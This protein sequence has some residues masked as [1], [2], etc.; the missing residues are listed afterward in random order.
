MAAILNATRACWSILTQGWEAQRLWQLDSLAP[1]SLMILLKG[2]L[3]Q[4][5]FHSALGA[6]AEE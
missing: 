1:V 4:Q 6:W 5:A 3:P 2:M